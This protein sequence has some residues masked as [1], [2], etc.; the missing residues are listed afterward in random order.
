M[1]P[2][3]S[4]VDHYM[5]FAML[6]NIYIYI[7]I[8][9]CSLWHGLDVP[10]VWDIW[11]GFLSLTSILDISTALMRPRRPKQYCLQLYIYIYIYIYIENRWRAESNIYSIVKKPP[12]NKRLEIVHLAGLHA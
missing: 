4:W 1:L 2:I 10:H 5:N 7:Y 12:Q 8:Y 6:G 3:I 9:I 11:G